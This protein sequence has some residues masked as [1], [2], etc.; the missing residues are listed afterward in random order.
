MIA[1]QESELTK[2]ADDTNI[3]RAI[4]AN[5]DPAALQDQLER[6]HEWVGKW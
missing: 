6:L 3:G 1:I 2:F 4:K 5:H